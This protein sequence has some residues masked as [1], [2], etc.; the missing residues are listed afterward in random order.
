VAPHEGEAK[1]Q[2]EGGVGVGPTGKTQITGDKERKKEGK[3]NQQKESRGGWHHA[4]KY[5]ETSHPEPEARHRSVKHVRGE[6]GGKE[7]PAA[8]PW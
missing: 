8:S 7:Q 3:R 2:T 1:P 6:W 5:Q 4:S